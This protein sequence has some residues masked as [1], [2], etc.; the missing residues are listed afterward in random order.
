MD[1]VESVGNSSLQS[2]RTMSPFVVSDVESGLNRLRQLTMELAEDDRILNLFFDLSP[3]MFCILDGDGT[4]LKVNHAWTEM[5]GW[6]EDEI[7]S[8]SIVNFMHSRDADRVRRSLDHLQKTG[9]MRFNSRVCRKD[10]GHVGIE[11]SVKK[12]VNGLTIVTGR[13]RSI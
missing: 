13:A 11:W 2:H 1:L 4:I 12:C 7:L 10:L 6:A 9:V 8:K 5:L 3:D